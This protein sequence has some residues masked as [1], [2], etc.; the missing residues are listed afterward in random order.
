[1]LNVSRFRRRCVFSSVIALSMLVALGF[2]SGC[3]TSN[4]SNGGT[5]STAA[6][7]AFTAQPSNVGAGSSIAPAVAVSIEDSSGN[8][9]TTATNQVTIAIGTNPANG[10]L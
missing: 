3:T 8:V 2:V 1:M 6:K 10:T 4:K 5:G 9:V 7:L